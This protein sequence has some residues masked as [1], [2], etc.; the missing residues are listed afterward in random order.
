LTINRQ[1]LQEL[2]QWRQNTKRKPLILRGARQVGKTTLINQFSKE[3]KQYIHLN[4]ERE[5]DIHFFKEYNSPLEIFDAL[6]LSKK[7]KKDQN[8]TLLFIDEIQESPKA[9]KLLR[10]FYEDMPQLKVIAAGSLLEFALKEVKSFPV[11][12]IEYLYLYPINFAEFLEATNNHS[13]LELMQQISIPKYAN[14]LL[15]KLYHKFCI[16]GGMPEIISQYLDN[17]ETT[18]GLIQIYESIWSSY[19][20]DVEKYSSNSTERR[21]IKHVIASAHNYL[22][23][24]I[25]FENFGNSNYRSREVGE[26]FRKLD[27]ARIIRLIYPST[28]IE[29]PILPDLKKSPRMQFL[30]T[31]I[32]NHAIGL[33]AELLALDDLSRAYKGTLIPHMFTQELMSLSKRNNDKPNFWVREKRQSSAEVDLIINIDNKIIPIE[34]K[35]GKVGTLKSLHQFVERCPHKYA[36]RV[37]N[38]EFLIEKSRTPGGK[39]YILMHLPYYLGT[40]LERYVRY[41][42]DNY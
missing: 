25:K 12:R 22:D 4:L 1:I 36:V 5:K 7:L 6:I 24:R 28:S 27:D 2:R 9:I 19:K 29:P 23:Q 34:I 15:M 17:G 26:A 11:G 13:A 42:L 39:D 18:A 38:G 8:E 31:G 10:Y 32:L 16:L 33:Q 14:D 40:Q 20:D 3:F 41:F 37:Y 35:S 30:D 21:I